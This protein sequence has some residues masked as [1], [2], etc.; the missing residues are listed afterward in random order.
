MYEIT[1][2]IRHFDVIVDIPSILLLIYVESIIYK[3]KILITN[4]MNCGSFVCY[5]HLQLI[6]QF[7]LDEIFVKLNVYINRHISI[8]FFI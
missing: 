8:F 6:L 3:I 1:G 2:K 7:F 5:L 4:S